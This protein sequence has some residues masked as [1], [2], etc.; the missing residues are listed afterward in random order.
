MDFEVEIRTY[1]KAV[2]ADVVAQIDKYNYIASGRMRRNFRVV[3]NQ[4]LSGEIR[5]VFYMNFL[6]KGSK[7]P[8]GVSRLFVDNIVNWMNSRRIQPKRDGIPVANTTT[9]IRRS[10]YGIAKG[11]V[12][13]GTP[14]TRGEKNLDIV[15]AMERHKRPYLE[16]IGK[17]F[18]LE[19]N[20]KLTIK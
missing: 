11:I 20:N 3:A 4:F 19:F 13:N 7:K 2:R 6:Q 5:G 16:S 18:L 9:N 12:M 8:K 15:G 10:A 17:E 14:A 1:L